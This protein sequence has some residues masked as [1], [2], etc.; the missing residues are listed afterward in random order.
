[1]VKKKVKKSKGLSR[2]KED[3]KLR[4]FIT[5]F[6]SIIGFVIALVAWKEDKYV[7]FYA[8]QSLV[9]FITGCVAGVLQMIVG[10]F[11]IIGWI[12]S[13]ALTV[14]VFVLWLFSWIYALS[15]EMKEVPFVGHFGKKFSL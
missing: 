5:T 1:M 14:V 15:G 7:M 10:I 11:P 2:D 6:L 13:F 8:K 3:Y 4:A 9:V 12:V